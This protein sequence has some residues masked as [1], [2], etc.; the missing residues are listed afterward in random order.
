VNGPDFAMGEFNVSPETD[1][2]SYLQNLLTEYPELPLVPP[3]ATDPLWLETENFLPDSRPE[4]HEISISDGTS[5]V[6]DPLQTSLD[7]SHRSGMSD[8]NSP[9]SLQGRTA[10]S[11]RSRLAE[12]TEA[13]VPSS[14]RDRSVVSQYPHAAALMRIIECLEEQLQIPR[15]PIDQAMRLNRQ[16]MVKVREMSKTDEFRRCQSCPLLVA[17]VM[18]LAVGLYELVILS[19]QRPAGEGDTVHLPDQNNV[20]WQQS[21]FQQP[22]GMG[23]MSSGGSSPASA[24]SGGSEPP[25]FQFGCLE[26]DPDEQEIFRSAMIRRDLRRCIETIQYCS[27]EILQRSRQ[28]GNLHGR[29]PLSR[30]VSQSRSPSNHA[31]TQWYQEM[32]YRAKELMAAIPAQC[33]HK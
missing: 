31:H 11:V 24:I 10:E 15:V 8:E 7:S 33:S 1:I 32:G 29:G 5:A 16:A 13:R 6:R 19:I 20:P 3:D 17:T 26:F 2:N 25:L 22:A 12:N 30:G 27:Q 21:P 23:E 9:G 14:Y 18:D 28:G 4:I